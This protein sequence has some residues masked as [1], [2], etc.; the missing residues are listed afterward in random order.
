VE[1][2]RRSDADIAVAVQHLCFEFREFMRNAD[3]IGCRQG[4]P[5]LPARGA[6][7]RRSLDLTTSSLFFQD[8]TDRDSRVQSPKLNNW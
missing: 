8:P 4:V 5:L 6:H 3:R 7:Y 2:E 1:R